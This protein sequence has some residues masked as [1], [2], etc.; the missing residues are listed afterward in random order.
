MFSGPSAAEIMSEFLV[1]PQQVRQAQYLFQSG[2]EM[3]SEQKE[4]ARARS[5]W[6][7]GQLDRTGPITTLKS[8]YEK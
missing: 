3:S 2:F 1:A 6:H 7:F 4:E 8:A 5:L